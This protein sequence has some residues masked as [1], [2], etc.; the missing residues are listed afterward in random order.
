MN[1]YLPNQ[2]AVGGVRVTKGDL[3]GA[4][5]LIGMDIIN[6]G[7]FAVTNEGG[8]TKFCF[9]VPSEGG[10]DFVAEH[11]RRLLPKRGGSGKSRPKKHKTFGKNKRR[12]KL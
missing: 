6:R 3:I 2:F 1:L 7:D 9:R 4:Q 8:I 5:M 11:N 12:K 10:I